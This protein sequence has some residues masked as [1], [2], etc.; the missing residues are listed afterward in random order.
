MVIHMKRILILLLAL[1]LSAGTLT[2]CNPSE[3]T[4][5]GEMETAFST[6]ASAESFAEETTIIPPIEWPEGAPMESITTYQNPIL[7]YQTDQAW[8]GY[9]FGD[10]FVM[11]YNG[12][13]YLYVSTKDGSVGIK[14]W[15]SPDLVN[16]HYEGFCT[17]DP[18]TR[19]AYAPEVYYYNGYFYMYTSPAGNGHYVLRSDSPTKGFEV[20]TDN[21]GMSIDGSVFMDND[22][23]WYFYTAGHG[24]MQVYHMTSPT[25]MKNGRPL[26]SVSVNN[27]WT[28]GG[29]VV[30]HDGYYYITYTGNHVLS[31][32]YRI[33]YGVSDT[34]PLHFEHMKEENP[35]LISTSGEVLGIGHSSTVKGPDLDSYYIVYHALLDTTPNRTM[36][37]DRIVFNG[38]HIEI[39]GPTTVPQQAP[40]LPDIYHRFEPGSSLKGWSLIGS[41]GS[42]RVGLSLAAESMLISKTHFA[43]DFT[44]EYNV[45][46]IADD[47]RAGALFAYTDAENFG[48]C[49]FSPAEQKVIIEITV[50]GNTTRTEV[51]T[52]HSFGEDTRFDCLQSIQIERSG[53]DYTFYMNDR[54]LYT[55][56]NSD[57]SGGAI[58]YMTKDN[59]ASFGF[60]GGTEAVG[61]CGGKDLFKAVSTQGG[62]IPAYECLDALPTITLKNGQRA[63][64]ASVGDILSYRV[65]TAADGEYDLSILCHGIE[66]T[67]AIVD[68]YVNGQQVGSCSLPT[69]RSEAVTA[70]LRGI[71]LTAGQHILSLRVTEGSF[72][73]ESLT[74]RK[75]SATMPLSVTFDTDAENPC[76]GDGTWEIIDGALTLSSSNSYGKVL[77]GS[78]NWGDY[79][80]EVTVTPKTSPNCGLLVR[81]TNPGAPTFMNTWPSREDAAIATDWVIGYFV[82]LTENSVSIGK[83]SYSYREIAQADGEFK[84]GTAYKLKVI[85]EGAR[86]QV[87]VDGELY[88]DYIDPEPYM[89]GMIGVRACGCAAVFDDLTVS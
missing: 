63:V 10:P 86:I 27:G 46:S 16:W 57:L 50:A 24:A 79:E 39:M 5:S 3:P 38:K 25:Q 66:T 1:L 71:H 54:L 26:T 32:S 42:G 74:M 36:N 84:A 14:C 12:I 22:G 52:V 62:Y 60:I 51:D 75:G 28:E 73:A 77:Y 61:G 53:R 7:T 44:A 31:P 18:L 29:M 55:L 65:L 4:L 45:T 58:G 37:I 89:Q 59:E 67:T 33:L 68:V 82:G 69:K 81:A 13:Y 56:E 30:F 11:R 35:L 34:S 47:G 85:C 19:G 72:H 48:A 76:Y 64:F 17:N 6:E 78:P 2:S 80:V 40:D 15:S 43:G 41:L 20:I 83:Q 49:Y 70:I 88:V 23:K 21:V 87:Y 8:P 9:G